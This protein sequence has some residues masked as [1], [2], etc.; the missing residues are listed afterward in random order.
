MTATIIVFEIRKTDRQT[1]ERTTEG[2]DR[3]RNRLALIPGTPCRCLQP[4]S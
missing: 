4:Q 2:E 1:H 3:L